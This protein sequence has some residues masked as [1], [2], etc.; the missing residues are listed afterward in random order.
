MTAQV[1]PNDVRDMGSPYAF[2][3]LTSIRNLLVVWVAGAESSTP[4]CRHCAGQRYSPGR[5]KASAPATLFQS[6]VERSEHD[7]ALPRPS[8]RLPRRPRLFHVLPQ[9]LDQ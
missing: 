4:R 3:W 5:R 2:A 7:L 9:L 6:L 1:I 8:R